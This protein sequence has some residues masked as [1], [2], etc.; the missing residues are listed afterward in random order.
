MTNTIV[1]KGNQMIPKTPPSAIDTLRSYVDKAKKK[2]PEGNKSI[3]PPCILELQAQL[4]SLNPALEAITSYITSSA[5]LAKKHSQ[6]LNEMEEKLTILFNAI[7]NE[8]KDIKD[9]STELEEKLEM[10]FNWRASK[11][12]ARDI[13]CTNCDGHVFNNC[14]VLTCDGCQWEFELK[15]SK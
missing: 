3:I 8:D 1:G 7:A 14:G 2:W 4:D 13:P 15:E 5:E 9:Q 6:R 10:L 12:I 11:E